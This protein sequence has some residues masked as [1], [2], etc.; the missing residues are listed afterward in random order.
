MVISE[1][2]IVLEKPGKGRIVL[3]GIDCRK[4]TEEISQ[5]IVSYLEETMGDGLVVG[6]SGG[7]DSSL[8][9]ALCK[10]AIDAW[11]KKHGKEGRLHALIM[12]S[13]QNDPQDEKDALDIAQILGLKERK[14]I[15]KDCRTYRRIRIDPVEKAFTAS[16]PESF[17]SDKKR[18]IAHEN[19]QSRIRMTLL[20]GLKESRLGLRVAGTGNRDEDYGLGYFTKYGDGGV[21]LSPIGML[22]KRLVRVI[23]MH[24]SLPERIICKIPTAGLRRGQTDAT[25]LGV[26]YFQAE[27]IISAK[28]QGQIDNLLEIIEHTAANDTELRDEEK[29][30][31]SA[32]DSRMIRAVL[33]RHD[34]LTKHKLEPPPVIK[35][36]SFVT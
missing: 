20:Y 7:V 15:S 16:M 14:D 5:G 33:Y 29:S 3:P 23:A 6:L 24:N 25:D 35:V 4:A 13:G 18:C 36:N 11:E 21:D 19:M 31:L 32:I 28:D 26:R 34:N 2:R 30:L 8:T 17:A 27:V 12:S 10:R 22:S 9:A 1:K